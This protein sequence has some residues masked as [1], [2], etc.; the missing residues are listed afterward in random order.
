MG[1]H[2][3]FDRSFFVIGG[4]VKTSGGSLDL[5]KGQL[6]LVDA[7]QTS[8][9]GA[10]V[11]SSLAGIA[12]DKKFLEL[13]LGIDER[14]PNRSHSNKPMVS[15]PFSL[16]EVQDIKVSAPERLEQRLDEVILG[17]NG[18]DTATTFNLESGETYKRITV[19]I[20]GD[21]ISYLGGGYDKEVVSV[22]FE[23]PRCDVFNDCD[24]C[25]PCGAVD[26]KA[27][28]LNVIETLNTQQLPGGTLLGDMIEI[29][30]VLSC[31]TP[32]TEALTAQDFYSLEVC[33]T[34]DSEA[35]ALVQVQYDTPVKRIDRIGSKSIYQVLLPQ[36]SGAPTD[37]AQTI[38]SIIKG[39]KDC[40][41]GYTE[42]PGGIVYAITMEDDGVDLTATIQALPGAVASTAAKA[43]GQDAGIGFYTV[44][45]D[46][47]LTDAE[48]TTFLGAGAPNAT[49]TF[50]NL[51]IVSAMCENS[52]VTNISWAVGVTCN[53]TEK[54]YLMDL[55]DN[56]CG[57]DRLVELQ[58]AYPELTISIATEA[59]TT[60]TLTFTGTGGTANVTI[61]GVNY[62]AT[63]DTDLSTTATNFVTTHAVAIYAAHGMSIEAVGG[64]VVFVGLNENYSTVTIA[65]AS[66]DL[67]GT[68]VGETVAQAEIRRGCAT[69][70]K[71]IVVTNL[72]CDECDDIFLDI[73]KAEAPE[74][75]DTVVWAEDPANA[76]AE[77][78]GNCKC[79]I[80]FKSKPFVL[81]SGECLRD[82][83]N[84]REDSVRIRVSGGYPEEVREGIGKTPQ[85]LF[86]V[87]R[88]AKFEP[89][90]HL[91]GNLQDFEDADRIYFR[92]EMVGDNLKRFLRGTESSVQDQLK[93]YVD[94]AI[95]VSHS[96]HSQGFG[97]RINEDITY[98]IFVEVGRHQA[99]ENLLNAI[100]S[101]AGVGAVVA[102]GA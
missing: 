32:S 14:Q 96:N 40:P 7:S 8:S 30:P 69:R 101:A 5:V 51:G 12:K 33:D 35:L 47:A 61:D 17:Y 89:R 49:A 87:T 71:A 81:K 4:A 78:S 37:Y 74:D 93:Q 1:L 21:A 91:G 97:G 53:V 59:G 34:G 26:C 28:T 79:G 86:S 16:G 85:E 20:Y 80:R 46:N 84:F 66:V 38:A 60:D 18:I 90:T 48:I 102:L 6:A 100:A 23:I 64:T 2:K 39:C 95:T 54:G 77:T 44:V 25:D 11:V 41:A 73:F 29:T 52:T 57:T 24:T 76:A 92:D 36:T 45:L 58:S 98:H 83:I 82:R 65:N 68:L 27:W 55:S 15:M 88:V 75:Y 13:R 70:Y 56:E 62:L 22:N 72:V 9:A 3:P 42:A 99:V 94:Y 31:D 67:A 50:E 19:E 10:K 43:S 63:F